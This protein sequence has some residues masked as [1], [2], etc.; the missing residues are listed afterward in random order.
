M[1]AAIIY[2][3][4]LRAAQN[5]IADKKTSPEV[6]TH[7]LALRA[8]ANLAMAR[9]AMTPD[10]RPEDLTMA[11]PGTPTRTLL[12]VQSPPVADFAPEPAH[13]PT[14]HEADGIWLND[15]MDGMAAAAALVV[16]GAL[17]GSVLTILVAIKYL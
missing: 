5:A 11:E 16:G 12:P 6:L 3:P 17:L 9:A 14:Q 1:T 2:F 4:G 7:A 13:E 8:E 15:F 10:T